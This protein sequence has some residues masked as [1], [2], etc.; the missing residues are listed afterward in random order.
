MKLSLPAVYKTVQYSKGDKELNSASRHF[1]LVNC[2]QKK[3]AT[4]NKT[5]VCLIIC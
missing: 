2:L 4:I 5:D 3:V 1:S